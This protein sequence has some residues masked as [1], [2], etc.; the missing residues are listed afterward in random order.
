[1]KIPHSLEI[2]RDISYPE[3]SVLEQNLPFFGLKSY[4]ESFLKKI[5]DLHY[6]ILR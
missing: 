4:Q 2:S 1:M 6:I 3:V 5:K